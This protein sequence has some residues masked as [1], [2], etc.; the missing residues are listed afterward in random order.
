MNVSFIA[1]FWFGSKHQ[2]SSSSQRRHHEASWFVD[3]DVRNMDV[4]NMD[5][6][7]SCSQRRHRDADGQPSAP[8]WG[9]PAVQRAAARKP[10]LPVIMKAKPKNAAR[11]L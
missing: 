6:I 1:I 5:A 10:V 4:R 7:F 11:V 3:M 9:Q 2:H 8:G